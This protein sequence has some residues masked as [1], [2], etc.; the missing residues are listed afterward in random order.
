MP[1]KK[2]GRRPTTLEEEVLQFKADVNDTRRR[3][4]EIEAALR[5]IGAD[6]RPSSRIRGLSRRGKKAKGAANLLR[7]T[8]TKKDK[9][10]TG[11]RPIK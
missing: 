10:I 11:G 9:K 5:K 1:K 7:D 6:K 3:R 4:E 8:L 2:L